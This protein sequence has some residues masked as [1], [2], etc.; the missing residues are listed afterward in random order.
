VLSG[1][2]DRNLG[3]ARRYFGVS[4]VSGVKAV[5]CRGGPTSSLARSLPPGPVP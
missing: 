5:S 3:S 1:C 2:V 4:G